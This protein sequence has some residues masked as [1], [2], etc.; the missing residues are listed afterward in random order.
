[1]K[2]L[3][4]IGAGMAGVT[5]AEVARSLHSQQEL[6]ITVIS[7]ENPPS[8]SRPRLPEL[9]AGTIRDQELILHGEDWFSQQGIRLLCPAEATRICPQENKLYLNMLPQEDVLHRGAFPTKTAP[10]PQEQEVLGYD[11]LILATGSEAFAPVIPDPGTPAAGSVFCLRS[12]QDVRDIRRHIATRRRKA[13]VLGG[14]LLGLEAARSLRATGVE[15]VHVMEASGYLLNRQLN[16]TASEMLRLYL[17]RQ[18][19]LFIHT[20]V[21]LDTNQLNSKSVAEF[22]K[23]VC[24]D[25]VETLV[26]SM[27]VRS[28]IS[29]AR[30]AG[31]AC[32]KG[33]VVDQEMATQGE[34][35]ATWNERTDTRQENIFACGDCAQ[36][37]GVTWAIIPAALEQGKKAAQFACWHLFQDTASQKGH[38]KP[39]PYTQ[40]IPRTSITIGEREAVSAGKAVLTAEEENSGRWKNH[41]VAPSAKRGS[42]KLGETYINLVEDTESGTIVGGLAFGPSGTASVQPLA[43]TP[44]QWLP[45]LKQLVGRSWQEGEI[46]P[47]P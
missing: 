42:S 22:L 46:Q 43:G 5:A 41:E 38:T 39:A 25:G 16:R 18:E 24:G 30:A 45:K 32:E 27:G 6:S 20:G 28:Q 12:L 40:T 2:H 31:L 8:Y 37:Q 47:E 23:P 13:A 9:L 3:I 15:E 1:M 29:L 11:A 44:S 35:M 7:R 19:G 10:S 17:E 26:Y 4:I 34:D 21:H 36:F 33:I 14:G